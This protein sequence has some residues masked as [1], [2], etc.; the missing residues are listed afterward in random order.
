MGMTFKESELVI[1]E[2]EEFQ[3]DVFSQLKFANNLVNLYS[4]TDQSL[5]VALNG[6]FGT[7]KS[8]FI[9]RWRG[10]ISHKADEPI[11]TLYFNAHENDFQPNIFASIVGKMINELGADGKTLSHL[12]HA[13]RTLAKYVAKKSGLAVIQIVSGGTI[14][15]ETLREI[16]QAVDYDH[17]EAI[18]DIIDEAQYQEKAID[19]FR[20]R[21]KEYINAQDGQKV[22][23]IIDE[24]DRCKPNY[25][26]NLLEVIKHFFS[27]DGLSFLLVVNQK[28]LH[29]SV[30]HEYGQIN[31]AEYLEKFIDLELR[32]PMEN[33]NHADFFSREC[34]LRNLEGSAA[35][36]MLKAL[37]G[38]FKPSLRQIQKLT[39]KMAAAL[40]MGIYQRQTL[41]GY[42][43]EL[44][45]GI[46]VAQR[47]PDIFDKILKDNCTSS[48]LLNVM[49]LIYDIEADVIEDE[50]RLLQC[51]AALIEF[52][53]NGDD[54]ENAKAWLNEQYGGR[55]ILGHSPSKVTLRNSFHTLA[56]LS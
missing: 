17:N 13:S 6:Y 18:S 36:M 56:S 52:R 50:L 23:F 32:L 11:K 46:W 31:S 54:E 41:A 29:T 2:G 53:Q 44:A 30:A 10:H 33:V 21:L 14:N 22:V 15:E 26:L 39:N 27:V 8:T 34:S 7:G 49:G 16:R 43:W 55:H 5:V 12:K 19:T 3:D 20:L 9:D 35:Q 28:Q 42:Q 40:A 24:L 45:L 38:Q 48:E 4:N 1:S 25:A 37:I 51:L 47:Y